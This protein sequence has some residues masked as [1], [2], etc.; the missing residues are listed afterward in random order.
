MNRLYKFLIISLF[1]LVPQLIKAQEYYFRF[2]EKDKI[3]INTIITS[4]IS[5]DNVVGDTIYAYANAVEF[6][7]FKALGYKIESLPHPSTPNKS[8]VMA[9]TVE[10]MANWD[11]Y[12]TYEVYRS[13]MKKFEKDYPDL[14]KLDSIGTTVLGRKI[15]VV[16]ISD[17]VL[18]NEAEPE[19][20]YTST[21]HGDETTGYI[22]MLR[23]ID[24]LLANY[25]TNPRVTN[26][27]NNI[28]IYINPNANPD[29]TYN[30]GNSTVDGSIRANA[31]GYDLNRNFPDPR[32]G[33]NPNG[34]HQVETIAMMNFATA[35]NFV[36]SANF[37]GG[38]EL[39]NYPWDTWTSSTRPHADNSWF[40][41]ISRQYATLTQ[42]N[43]PS[44]YFTGMYNGVT[45]GGD[46]YVVA[47]G[48]QDY[49][50]YWHNCREITLEV[51]NT[52]NPASA[53]LPKFW[54][55]NKEAMLSYMELVFTGV[56]GIVTNSQ[57]DP[58]AANISIASHDKDNS[59]VVT[60]AFHGNYVRMIAPNTY[61]FTY[62]SSGYSNSVVS[63]VSVSPNDMTI[64]NVVL[65]GNNSNVSREVRILDH[66]SLE[67]IANAS[68]VVK[69]SVGSITLNTNEEGLL[70]L[71]NMPI[72]LIRFDVSASGYYDSFF[73]ERIVVANATIDLKIF[74][75]PRYAV[76]FN[77]TKHG[78][79]AVVGA[80]IIFNGIAKITNDDGVAV[81]D[82]IQQGT[83]NYHL[84]VEGFT[85]IDNNV[86]VST[87][88]TIDINL[89]PLSDILIEYTSTVVKTW[90]NPFTSTL[91]IEVNLSEK[92]NLSVDIFSVTGQKILSLANGFHSQ[93][94][95]RFEW[96]TQSVISSVN[97]GVYVVRV[98][99]NGES[100]AYRVIFLPNGR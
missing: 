41:S 23:L 71:E 82:D 68:V 18:S 76:T 86:L 32:V 97:Q 8:R 6:E 81:F 74:K 96:K 83:Y 44:G 64:V 48:R 39:A 9:T 40:Y 55:Y 95:H 87:D 24:Y 70:L 7:K 50:N 19:F 2:V 28:A 47:G 52:K 16:K 88:M 79:Q 63:G 4:T 35:R 77:V 78:D 3:L 14:C 43:S 22:L 59:N 69:S 58:L 61:D 45:H 60:N 73:L 33:Q 31:M 67:P 15:Y 94:L 54:N 38:I 20:F 62:S 29:G 17:N 66:H 80:E 65:G 30:Y 84:E 91:N 99:T 90:P 42:N 72:G 56:H 85:E 46:W 11:R 75:T 1:L 53:D 27:V 26:L 13:M 21:M 36:L 10:Q 100:K 5:I 57:G 89:T 49:M 37:H 93:G 92:T 34:P 98:V 25:G 51:S 12:P